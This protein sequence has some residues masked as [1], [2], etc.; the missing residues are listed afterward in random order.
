MK[1]LHLRDCILSWKDYLLHI[2]LLVGCFTRFILPLLFYALSVELCAP[3]F[4]HSGDWAPAP[5]RLG[6]RVPIQESCINSIQEPA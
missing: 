1:D 4:D 2:L 5:K 6:I 3:P